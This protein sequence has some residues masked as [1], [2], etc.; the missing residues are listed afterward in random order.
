MPMTIVSDRDAVFFNYFR[1]MFQAKL[2]TKFLFS[3]T[4]LS[5]IDGQT[6][7]VNKALS[8]LLW[9]IIEK[10]IKTWEDCLSH[11]EFEIV[12]GLIL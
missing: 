1:K 7:V 12:Y 5:Q 10:N 2:G 8:S 3:T 6:E 11:L 9:A 4:Y